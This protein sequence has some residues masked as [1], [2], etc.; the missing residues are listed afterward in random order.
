MA[1]WNDF[2]W[3]RSGVTVKKTGARVNF[4]KSLGG[5]LAKWLPYAFIERIRAPFNVGSRIRVYALPT[6]PRYWY[7]LRVS[8]SRLGVEFVDSVSNADIALYFD[9]D[10][11][12]DPPHLLN[13]PDIQINFECRDISKTHVQTC[14]LYTSPSP[15]DRTRS[16]MPSSA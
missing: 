12:S 8:L 15:R 2:K 6:I 11:Y 7:L 16:R 9:D 14:L 10:T 5:D 13:G 4:D 3:S 1:W